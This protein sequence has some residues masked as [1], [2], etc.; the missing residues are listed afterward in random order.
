MGGESSIS[1]MVNRNA[2]LPI[3]GGSNAAGISRLEQ[4]EIMSLQNMIDDLTTEKL[5]LKR[6]MDKIR[7][8]S[9][10]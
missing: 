5:S 4:D 2:T 3:F 1:D 9:K 7:R 10:A 6:G 8:S